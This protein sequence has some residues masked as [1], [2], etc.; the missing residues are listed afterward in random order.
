M[1]ELWKILYT[2]R[3]ITIGYFKNI[4]TGYNFKNKNRKVFFDHLKK[5]KG[6]DIQ[7]AEWLKHLENVNYY[8]DEEHIEL[9]DN[10]L[11]GLKETYNSKT[12]S[13]VH[14]VVES[15]KIIFEKNASSFPHETLNYDL[16]KYRP[17]ACFLPNGGI[18]LKE[19][20]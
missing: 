13:T 1:K 6:E 4:P 2:T 10:E 11:E 19:K 18:R 20:D 15:E 3:F 5:I 8:C 16:R 12:D 7:S 14:K 17:S 9:L